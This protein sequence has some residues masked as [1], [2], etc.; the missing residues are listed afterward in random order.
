MH[1][2]TGRIEHAHNYIAFVEQHTSGK[3]MLGR[4]VLG[5]YIMSYHGPR[6]THLDISSTVNRLA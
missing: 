6:D 3:A 1:A 2:R 4:T 5:I